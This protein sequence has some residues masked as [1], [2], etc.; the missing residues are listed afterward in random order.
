MGERIANID[1]IPERPE[2][3]VRASC[4][5]Q[6]ELFFGPSGFERRDDRA[7]REERAKAICR[8][9][10]VQIVCL[11][12]ALARGEEHGIWGGTNGKER[13]VIL[14]KM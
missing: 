9:C 4:H 5:G 11:E 6:S 8:T 10:A 13:K 12:V 3:S 7:E 14:K 2:W 1:S